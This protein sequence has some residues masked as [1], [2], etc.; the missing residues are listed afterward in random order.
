MQI[1]VRLCVCVTECS[2]LSHPHRTSARPLHQAAYN[3]RVDAAKVLID[4]RADVHARDKVSL[5]PRTQGE[6][7]QCAWQLRP[8]DARGFVCFAEPVVVIKMKKRKK[9]S[10][11][12]QKD[13]LV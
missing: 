6:T 13:S 12:A 9:T 1:R 2:Q 3:N 11:F 10:L 8:G 4:H 7:A 5:N